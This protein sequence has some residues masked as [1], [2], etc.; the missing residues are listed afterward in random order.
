MFDQSLFREG[1]RLFI[2]D[3]D[4]EGDLTLGQNS[5]Y[6]PPWGTKL[7]EASEV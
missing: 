2:P 1:K 6:L 4:T 5:P 3:I 7:W